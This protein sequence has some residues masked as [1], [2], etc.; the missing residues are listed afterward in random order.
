MKAGTTRIL[1][2]TLAYG[3][4]CD[5]EPMATH[6]IDITNTFVVKRARVASHCILRCM[7]PCFPS[8]LNDVLE[9]PE[10]CD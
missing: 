10:I 3:F 5:E 4:G 2:S 8:T 6:N 7:K 1:S 9:V